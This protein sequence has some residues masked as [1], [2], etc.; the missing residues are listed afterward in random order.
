MCAAAFRRLIFQ[1]SSLSIILTWSHKSRWCPFFSIYGQPDPTFQLVLEILLSGVPLALFIVGGMSRSDILYR[2][3]HTTVSISLVVSL[4]NR[5]TTSS[6]TIWL[7]WIRALQ[8]FK[9]NIF[10]VCLWSRRMNVR[11]RVYQFQIFLNDISLKAWLLLKIFSNL[12]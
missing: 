3:C 4:V 5:L 7:E 10:Q 6:L 12:K 11:I 2:N 8:I 1:C 9:S